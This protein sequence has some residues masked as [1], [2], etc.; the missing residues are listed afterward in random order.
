MTQISDVALMRQALLMFEGNRHEDAR[1]LAL[2][3]LRR[4]PKHHQ[5]LLLLADIAWSRRQREQ[6][7]D[8]ARRVVKYFPNDAVAHSK[9]ADIYNKAGR[10]HE[11]IRLL[12][13]F[14]KKA[15]NHPVVIDALALSYE[16]TGDLGRAIELLEPFVQARTE[17]PA[18]AHRYASIKFEQKQYEQVIEVENRHLQNPATGPGLL[19]AMC[20]LLGRTYEAMGD[21]DK[22]FSAYNA[23]NAVLP[24]ENKIQN[25][26]RDHDEIIQTFSADAMKHLPRAR[27]QSRL[28]V[29]IVCKPR[30]GSTLVERIISAH[31]L[32]HE[33]GEHDIL[34]REAI[35]LS[36]T[37]GSILPW[38]KCVRDLDQNDVDQ[39]SSKFIAELQAMSPRAQRVTNKNLWTWRYLGLLALICPNAVVIDLRRDAL[40]NCLGIFTAHMHASQ[41]YARD[42]RQ[43]GLYH[44]EYERMMEHWYSVLD[45]PILKLKYED[46]VADPEY[47]AR[48]LIEHCG[49]Q[50]DDRCLRFYEKGAQQSSSAAPTL[51]FKQVR[52]PIY[53]SSVSR[54]KRFEKHLGP[55]YEAL[56]L[57]YPPQA[58]TAP[59]ADAD[60]A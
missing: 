13:K 44:R 8:Y 52:Q 23:A 51:S 28:P 40:D 27:N 60:S 30:S 56:G 50:W 38:P 48:R 10:H 18:M 24:S 22:A 47:W 4:N 16:Y 37:I 32:V 54:A 11:A 49:L 29:F 35:D 3:M 57:P 31:P 14:R 17:T 39:L 6:A 12:E 1:L 41:S 20:F 15:P 2:E 21:Y 45:L 43:I 25:A 26:V 5:A 59:T 55:L 7:I 9:L 42:L 34:Q 46:L 33:G 19:E 36:L 53:K 58:A